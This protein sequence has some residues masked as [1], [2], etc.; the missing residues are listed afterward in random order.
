MKSSKNAFLDLE[1]LMYK[2]NFLE[3]SEMSEYKVRKSN[4]SRMA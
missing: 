4:F 2:L 1:D 3:I